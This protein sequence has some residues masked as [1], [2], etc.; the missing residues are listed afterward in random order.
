[1]S[2]LLHVD[3]ADP[4]ICSSVFGRI[5]R[6]HGH[7][8]LDR[9]VSENGGSIPSTLQILQRLAFVR[10]KKHRRAGQRS[11]HIHE[12]LW[13]N[14]FVGL[15]GEA[16]VCAMLDAF[17]GW[18]CEN[19]LD[20]DDGVDIEWTPKV[21]DDP[22]RVEVKW[23]K[24]RRLMFRKR[25]HF[26]ESRADLAVLVFSPREFP[27]RVVARGW[28]EMSTFREVV[29]PMDS[30]DGSTSWFVDSEHPSFCQDM[31][32]LTSGLYVPERIRATW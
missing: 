29:A 8:F 11:E 10:W 21:G 30:K 22:V 7:A 19:R 9:L 5:C 24:T 2:S 28:I 14:D 26:E 32:L 31:N 6:V 13:K 17:A 4:A 12:R 25:R 18:K 15:C 20:A 16:G 23:S 27:N 1:M 3:I